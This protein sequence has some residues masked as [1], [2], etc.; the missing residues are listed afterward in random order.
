[1]MRGE[2]SATKV[3]MGTRVAFTLITLPAVTGVPGW[4]RSK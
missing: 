1:M 4:L 3:V 2:G